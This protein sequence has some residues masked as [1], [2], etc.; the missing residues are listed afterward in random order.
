VDKKLKSKWVKAL[1]SGKFKRG[2]WQLKTQLGYC[3]LGVLCKITDTDFDP[4]GYF[5]PEEL[6]T[7]AELTK[8]EQDTL[9][10]INDGALLPEG[11]PHPAGYK[12]G[13]KGLSF[14]QIA[15]YIRK[16]IS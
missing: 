15:K 7:K 16:H 2:K 4:E 9:S 3:C 11:V 12:E 6:S 10:R 1:E 5:L 14:R 13:G 8:Q